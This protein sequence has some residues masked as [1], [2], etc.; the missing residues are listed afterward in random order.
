MLSV[1]SRCWRTLTRARTRCGRNGDAGICSRRRCHS[2]AQ[3]CRCRLGAAL[4]DT[5]SDRDR[6]RRS[7]QRPSRAVPAPPQDTAR[8]SDPEIDPLDRHHGEEIAMGRQMIKVS[9]NAFAALYAARVVR[10]SQTVRP[11]PPRRAMLSRSSPIQLRPS[12]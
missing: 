7:R 9:A 10:A 2:T 12:L 4:R 8:G 5:G 11:V 3:C 1:P 6:D